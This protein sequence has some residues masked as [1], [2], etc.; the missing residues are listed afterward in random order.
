MFVFDCGE[1][2]LINTFLVRHIQ[3]FF[4]KKYISLIQNSSIGHPGCAYF[5]ICFGNVYI[6]GNPKSEPMMQPNTNAKHPRNVLLLTL[7]LAL[8]TILSLLAILMQM[9]SGIST[10]ICTEI[11]IKISICFGTVYIKGNPK[12]EPMMQ[13]NTNAEHL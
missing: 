1:Q 3:H 5:R 7:P 4:T 8:M 11:C 6:K 9:K 12:S 10:E 13:T 2:Y